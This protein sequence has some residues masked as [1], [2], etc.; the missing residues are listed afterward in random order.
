MVELLGLSL[1]ILTIFVSFIW[2]N[3]RQQTL[4]PKPRDSD[5][6]GKEGKDDRKQPQHRKEQRQ[7]QNQKKHGGNSTNNSKSKPK[8]QKVSSDPRFI[9]RYGGHAGALTS[10][11]VSPDGRWLATAGRDGRIRVAK[12]DE[13]G[14]HLSCTVKTAGTGV[15]QDHLSAISWLPISDGNNPTVV[16]TI[17]KARQIAFY[18]IRHRKDAARQRRQ[19][20]T[21]QKQN[22]S[23]QYE[24]IELAKRR[25]DI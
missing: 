14:F 15:F 5:G 24:L 3:K 20:S 16:G 21:T 18:R 17:H 9:R 8:S 19:G 25:F 7:D 12:L 6:N 10:F 1:A 11:S 13:A 23:S 4:S 2:W 22:S